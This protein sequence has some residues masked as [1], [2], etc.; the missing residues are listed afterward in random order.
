M[1]VEQEP[2]NI[3]INKYTNKKKLTPN[4]LKALL[5]EPF[6]YKYKLL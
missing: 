5:K 2:L 6:C 1:Q 3:L 4:N